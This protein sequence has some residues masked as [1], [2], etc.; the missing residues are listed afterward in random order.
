MGGRS[1]II[2]SWPAQSDG[3]EFYYLSHYPGEER[4]VLRYRAEQDAEATEIALQ[5]SE[6]L[7]LMRS[8]ATAKDMD[9]VQARV[10]AGAR[11]ALG[12]RVQRWT[13]E[14]AKQQGR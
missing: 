4:V 9:P 11:R 6:M 3:Y 12:V 8:Q 14:L 5:P 13:K 7:D 10:W 1:Y 2:Y